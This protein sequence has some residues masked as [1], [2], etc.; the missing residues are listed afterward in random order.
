[1]NN[2]ED[3]TEQVR[4]YLEEVCKYS[5]GKFINHVKAHRGNKLQID[6][7]IFSGEIYT[8]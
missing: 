2:F 1:M 7:K 4:A 8:G 5:H 6:D 3:L